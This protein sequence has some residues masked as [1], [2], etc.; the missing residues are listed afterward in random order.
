MLIYNIKK[1]EKQE[2]ESDTTVLATSETTETETTE[3]ET[4]GIET[5][6]IETAEIETTEIETTEAYTVEI[7][8]TETSVAETSELVTTETETCTVETTE[9][10]VTE[11]ESENT[12]EAVY[13]LESGSVWHNSAD[14]R[15]LK[16]KTFVSGTVE[17]AMEHGKSKLCS[18]CEKRE[19]DAI[20]TEAETECAA[21]EP[22]TE[23]ERIEETGSENHTQT[24][25]WLES[26][27]VWHY[28][29]ECS[30]IKG[31]DLL[32]GS[33]EEALENG[34]KRACKSCG[35]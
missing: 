3:I 13:W 35:Q 24:V 8:V 33:V 19:D 2:P 5:T 28:K 20:E 15:Y 7:I 30:H 32:S 29:I 34:M 25:Y 17:Q 6:E 26:G 21:T 4:T 27:E 10:D 1:A 22:E 11:T 9:P 14:C 31:K 23:T 12:L 16:G 18:A